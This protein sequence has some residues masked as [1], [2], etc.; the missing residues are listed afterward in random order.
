MKS[1]ELE[2]PR[3]LKKE[4][5]I[6]SLVVTVFNLFIFCSPYGNTRLY[7]DGRTLLDYR[8]YQDETFELSLGE[9]VST[10]SHTYIDNHNNQD[11]RAEKK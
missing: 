8:K 9:N 5:T 1:F 7:L 10:L 11:F 2:T 3:N 6:E 4:I